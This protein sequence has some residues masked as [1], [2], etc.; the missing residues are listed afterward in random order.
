MMTAIYTRIPPDLRRLDARAH[1][2]V[3]R[4]NS[5]DS[6]RPRLDRPRKAVCYLRRGGERDGGAWRRERGTESVCR[7]L[8]FLV[9]LCVIGG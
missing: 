3:C 1:R 4:A 9:I 7:S 2:H 6:R 5:A 8:S